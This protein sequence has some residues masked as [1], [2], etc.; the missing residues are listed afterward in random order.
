MH[1][2]RNGLHGIL[3]LYRRPVL[4]TNRLT[5]RIH[6]SAATRLEDPAAGYSPENLQRALAAHGRAVVT[7]PSEDRAD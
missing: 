1:V 5:E 3:P 6:W 4:E 2:E 7:D